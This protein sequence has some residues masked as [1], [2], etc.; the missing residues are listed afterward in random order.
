MEYRDSLTF[1]VTTRPARP[2]A[3]L[4]YFAPRPTQQ[5][6]PPLGLRSLV[7]VRRR[8]SYHALLVSNTMLN[9]ITTLAASKKDQR[10][11]YLMTFYDIVSTKSYNSTVPQRTQERLT[12]WNE[13]APSWRTIPT[14]LP[15]LHDIRALT[16]SPNTFQPS[17]DQL[18]HGKTRN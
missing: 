3:E 15:P 9:V 10:N 2:T 1:W 14:P 8:K 12:N 18:L 13:Y 16:V 11:W 4:P 17:R 6:V 7:K 5:T